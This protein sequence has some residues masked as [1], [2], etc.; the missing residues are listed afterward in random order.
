MS[1]RLL[2][3]TGYSLV[4]RKWFINKTV[5]DVVLRLIGWKI[6]LTPYDDLGPSMELHLRHFCLAA[7]G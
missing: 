7:A 1:L 2:P 6:R 5:S 4:F 3:I